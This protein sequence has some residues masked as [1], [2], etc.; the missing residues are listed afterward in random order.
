[1]ENISVDKEKRDFE[2]KKPWYI[3]QMIN[4]EPAA[5]S[6]VHY[7]DDIEINL[8]QNVTADIYVG[9]KDY[10][11]KGN[12]IFFI[13]PNVVH[14]FSYKK[15][16]GTFTAINISPARL[17]PMF[18]IEAFLAHHNISYANLPIFIPNYE[19]GY[20]IALQ[21]Q[22][23]KSLNDFLI[24]FLNFFQLLVSCM[25][26]ETDS[27]MGLNSPGNDSLRSIITWT[28]NN[29]TRKISVDEA[30][31]ALGYSKSYFCRKFKS[32]TGMTYIEFVNYLRVHHA[33][34]M[35][36]HGASIAQTCDECGFEDAS[37][38][39]KLFKK[40]IGMTPKKFVASLDEKT[41]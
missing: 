4:P 33:H 27:V 11:F 28:R 35:L 7:S 17:K 19:E 25:E 39:I 10:S 15:S 31:T 3:W 23:A 12:G 21:I 30:S 14:S 26:T 34:N 5:S 24:A 22:S 6:S 32:A 1:M 36:K 2:E 8:F 9:G 13:A 18:D 16:E 20:E 38:F 29:F 37:Y 40:H 41:K